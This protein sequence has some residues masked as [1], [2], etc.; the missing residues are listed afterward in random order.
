MLAVALIAVAQPLKAQF[1]NIPGEVTNAFKEKYPE[2]TDVSWND[3]VTSFQ[4]S[5][6]LDGHR[7]EARFKKD[8]KWEETEKAINFEDL[9]MAVQEAFNASEYKKWNLRTVAYIENS[10]GGKEYR[11]Y[12]KNDTVKRKYLYYG[13]DGKFL[14]DSYKI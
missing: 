11:I 12:V 14:R 2:A 6:A 9:P 10:V 4:A 3:K 5:F 1:R 8:G 7:Y 13:E